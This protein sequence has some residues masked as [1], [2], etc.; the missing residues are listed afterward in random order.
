MGVSYPNVHRDQA[1]VS[2]ASGRR[3][4]DGDM[5]EWLI[6]PHEKGD[7]GWSVFLNFQEK[8]EI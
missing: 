1:I 3:E 8:T 5:S 2:W 4:Y 7:P 6:L